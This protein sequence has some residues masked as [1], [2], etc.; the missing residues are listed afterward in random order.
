MDTQAPIGILDDGSFTNPKFDDPVE[1][2]NARYGFTF[3]SHTGTYTI[4]LLSIRNP[5]ATSDTV[6][7]YSADNG[8]AMYSGGITTATQA[9]MISVTLPNA[10][11]TISS[12]SPTTGSST[13]G[14]SVTI[15]GTGFTGATSVKFGSASAA[16]FTVDSATQITAVASAGAVGPADIVVTTGSG[17][18][19]LASGFSYLVVP[20]GAPTI[21]TVTTL[22]PDGAEVHFTPPVDT[23]G[24]TITEYVVTSSPHGKTGVGTQSPIAVHGLWSGISYTFT[25][26]AKN[27]AGAGPASV[28]SQAVVP[29][30]YQ[31]I[32]FNPGPQTFGTTPFLSAMNNAGI[33]VTFSSTAPDICAVTRYGELTF[34]SAGTCT[35]NADAE[36]NEAYHP[37]RVTRSFA[38]NPALPSAP[39][40]STVTTL[41]PDGAEVH[42]T[43]PVDTGGGTITEYVVTSSPHGKTGVGTE[44]PI[45]VHG[46]WS[47]ISYTFTV[48]AKNAA[49]AG[50]ASAAS[51]AVVPRNYQLI[52]FNPG[53]Q[54]FGTTPFLSAMN[55]AG[56][57]V[58]FSSTAPD[59]CAVTRYGELTFHSAG[60]CTIN[61]D[62]EG[63]EAYHPAR[64]TRS[65]AVNPALPSAPTIGT[66][67]AGDTKADVS[68]I[69]P[70][71]SGGVP[72]TYTATANP[73]GATGTGA[74]SPV[75][76]AGLTNGVAYTFSVTAT[77]AAGTGNASAASNSITPAAAQFITFVN[78]GVQNF[79][80]TPILTANSDSGLDPTFTSITENVCT[81]TSSGELTFA[82]AGTCTINANQQGNAAYLPAAQVT[83]SF[84]VHPV[85]PGAPLIGSATAGDTQATITFTPPASDGGSAVIDYIVTANPSGATFT[86]PSSPIIATAL[87]N[88]T[89]Y[90]FTV[91]TRNA[92]GTGASSAAS[93]AVTPVAAQFIAFANPGSQTV[94]T[95]STLT[96][97][98]SSGLTPTFSS[99][100]PSVCTI[101]GSATLTP[102][103]VGTCAISVD[104]SGNAAYLAA[105]TVT[106]S[107][108]VNPPLPT[109]GNASATVAANSTANP[110]TL[111][112]SGGAADSVAVT[113]AP[114][115]GTATAS[116][117]SIS[118]APDPGYSGSDSFTYTATNATGTSAPATVAV[119]VSAPTFA[120]TPAA[121]ALI[122]G[123]VGTAYSQSIS[124]ANGMAPYRYAL[125]T[126]AL[127]AGLR[128]DASSGAI[129]GTPTTEGT[130]G[131]TIEATDAN[132]A[133]GSVAYTLAI[134]RQIPA[135]G[136]A[137][138]TVAANSTANPVTLSLSGGAADSV[139][140]TAAPSHGTAT[141]SGTS[142]SYTPDPGYSGSDS[143]TYTATN[144]TGTSAPATVAVTVS[145]PTFA[146]TP[147]AGA[148][149]VGTVGTAYSQSISVANGMAPYRY[150][151]STGGLPAGLRLDASSGAITGT[152]TTEGAHGFTIEA[153]DANGAIGSA[154]YTV[155]IGRQIPV[156]GNVSA[157]VA[158]DSTAN[159]VT[160]SL[161]GGAADSVAVTSTPSHG[162]ATAS[163][164]TI[165]YAPD[166]GYS[167]ADS[168]T[169]TA[170]NTSGT[171][172]PA[173]V[174]IA[175]VASKLTFLPAGG[176]LPDAMAGEAYSTMVTAKGGRGGILY[177]H[178]R[179]ELPKG[180]ILNVST[181]ELTGPLPADAEVKT[182]SF[183]IA[184]RDVLGNTGEASYRLTV[185][186]RGVTV[187]NR[188]YTLQ[189]GEAPRNV[190]L[191]A[192]ATGGPFT[193]AGIAFVRPSN[194]GKAEIIEGELAANG[195]FVPVGYYLKF[196]PNPGF[197]GTAVVGY[198]LES[199]LGA[200]NTGTISYAIVHDGEKV[201]AEID[202]LVK[203]FVR[204][205]QNLLSTAIEVPGLIERRKMGR[206]G[207][208]PISTRMSPSQD[209]MTLGFSTSLAQL[210][211]ADEGGEDMAAM[212]P[213]NIWIDGTVAVHKRDENGGRWGSFGLISAGADYLLSEKALIG[214]SFHFDR[215]TDPTDADAELT[216]NGWL[217]G[218]Y[219]SFE[220]GSGVFLDTSL[221]Y[222]GSWNDV[223]T[224]YFDGSFDT[225]RVMWDTKLQGQWQLGDA[226][227]LTP[228][229][230]AV[231]LNEKVDDYSASND[232]GT[233][234]DLQ[235]FT[236]DQ[237]RFSV[238]AE[239]ERAYRVENGLLLR[240]RFGGTAGF[241][242]LDNSGAFGTVSAGLNLSNAL[243]W[244]F[245][246]SLLYGIESEGE[247]TVG[248]KAGVHVRF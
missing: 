46:L 156:A 55:N 62:A 47:G 195:A 132:G 19:T 182:Y 139:A 191:N 74:S 140:V 69:A 117:T 70:A 150:A 179:G 50:P 6:V 91:A 238:G 2:A 104:Q 235:G 66:A 208:D 228:A 126:G 127:P 78:P 186:A 18:A 188:S 57:P 116:G 184:A 160:L 157:T 241:A 229:L 245:D 41:D 203:D 161:S 96:A 107:F 171:S 11:P 141:A 36:G 65:F 24:G 35:I 84:T 119:T 192:G 73:G 177:S 233:R 225:S 178:S 37:A 187:T 76:V 83:Q 128:L 64:V 202:G 14:T 236:Q 99:S 143:F 134:G 246:F 166:P 25:V 151:V 13:G 110:V 172:A 68:F 103:A 121:G 218:P 180:M 1:T 227:V 214:L 204:T 194:A 40:I 123:T 209:G 112:L 44:S 15:T 145:A 212:S 135:A 189:E 77:N 26:T 183:A 115:H 54:T 176:D 5:V 217:A 33:P 52:T 230:R 153:T 88:G 159:S 12:V 199:A 174:S 142:I 92:A 105:P 169:Y 7:L 226:T 131:F 59:I 56:I 190:Y 144:A 93:N 87:T 221:L 86:A 51:Q 60:T 20:P 224:E 30:N 100:T 124:A 58:T 154:T 170:T 79:G 109:V 162:T 34:H 181:G 29:R 129:T 21:G 17:T 38:V 16:S 222:G 9:N 164:T 97:T 89:A 72:V 147:A 219:A 220:L 106:R 4:R 23:G 8:G 167:G 85:M 146:F 215:M 239:L 111:S 242:A 28:A 175:V 200:S 232:D 198:R 163:G 39:T 133:T 45:A 48:T 94:G 248:A 231:F 137:S 108:A 95:V 120:F 149:I 22:D 71:S 243:N 216:G 53:P 234:I 207:S 244:D 168:F 125:S 118:Y 113:A 49:G 80:T 43:P 81:I 185:K 158:A 210:R 165:S 211:S 101:T 90:T 27:A 152:P 98:V 67:T 63:N 213:F 10:F 247:Q 223:D 155:A 240:P 61:A 32:T 3:N 102:I 197:F 42:F 114:S 138:A 193:G 173:T 136:N 122:V 82:S 31:L 201:A 148:L 205:R 75:T 130:H 206:A 237:L 196:T